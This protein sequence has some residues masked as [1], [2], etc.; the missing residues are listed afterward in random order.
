MP[1]NSC[2]FSGVRSLALTAPVYLHMIVSVSR[3]RRKHSMFLTSL[4]CE[5]VMGD[6]SKARDMA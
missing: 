5:G 6:F 2:L 1:C 4:E 3:G